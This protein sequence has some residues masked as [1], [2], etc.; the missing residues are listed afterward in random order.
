MD[1]CLFALITYWTFLDNWI[2]LGDRLILFTVFINCDIVMI[3][4]YSD[5]SYIYVHLYCVLTFVQSTEH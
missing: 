4:F 3:I 5:V 1:S 2:L